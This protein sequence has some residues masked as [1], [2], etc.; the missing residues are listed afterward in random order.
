MSGLHE[1][2]LDGLV[3]L[4]NRVGSY[5]DAQGALRRCAG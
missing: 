1:K 4:T 3:R 2:L 5:T